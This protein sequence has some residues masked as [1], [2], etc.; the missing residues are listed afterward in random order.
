MF[1]TFTNSSL[2]PQIMTSTSTAK[3]KVISSCVIGSYI[4]NAEPFNLSEPVY[5]IIHLDNNHVSGSSSTVVRP[6]W[7]D[8]RANNGLGAWQTQYC[9]VMKERRDS[10]VFSCNRLGYYALLADVG[11]NSVM[12]TNLVDGASGGGCTTNQECACDAPFCS[13]HKFC[14]N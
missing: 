10:S 13:K 2:F 7:W 9:K 5:V 1:S 14:R 4:L 8:S 11:D 6:G 12:V 3:Y